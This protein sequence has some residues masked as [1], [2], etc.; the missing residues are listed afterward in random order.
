ML[1]LILLP[2]TLLKTVI[3]TLFGILMIP[4]HLLFGLLKLTFGVLAF[5]VQVGLWV[6]CILLSIA[7]GQSRGLN[8]V[9]CGILGALGPIGLG[10]VV[11]LAL[12]RPARAY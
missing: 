2:F 12:L 1:D 11:V 8:P 5:G 7:I 4:F 10:V 6:A 9:L 3:V